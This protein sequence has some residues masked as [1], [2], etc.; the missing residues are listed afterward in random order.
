MI[1]FDLQIRNYRK[2]YDA[3]YFNLPIITHSLRIQTSG[4]TFSVPVLCQY[5]WR[6]LNRDEIE[7]E[8]LAYVGQVLKCPL[9]LCE[10]RITLGPSWHIAEKVAFDDYLLCH[11]SLFSPGTQSHSKNYTQDV[12]IKKAVF[13]L[14]FKY[15]LFLWIGN[16]LLFYLLFFYLL[17]RFIY[18]MSSALY[19]FW[20]F[21]FI[22]E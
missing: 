10:L 21:S 20:Y 22:F 9:F 4:G 6:I 8:L 12:S 13:Q 3:T 18:Q 11:R 2:K 16:L 17:L 1:S 7:K 5:H 15:K 14:Q 19:V